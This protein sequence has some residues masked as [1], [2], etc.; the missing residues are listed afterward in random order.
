MS[1]KDANSGVPV[2][3]ILELP[4]ASFLITWWSLPF[5]HPPIQIELAENGMCSLLKFV[6]FF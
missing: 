3:I 2:K 1:V 4:Y 6:E 5:L